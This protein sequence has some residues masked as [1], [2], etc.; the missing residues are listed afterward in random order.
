[1]DEHGNT[2]QDRHLALVAVTSSRALNAGG[3][4]RTRGP[5]QDRRPPWRLWLHSLLWHR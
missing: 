4:G 1:M 5:Q 3:A 2:G